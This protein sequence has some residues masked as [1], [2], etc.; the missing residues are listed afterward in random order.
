MNI[1][2]IS[3]LYYES[4]VDFQLESL[5]QSHARFSQSCSVFQLTQSTNQPLP[6]SAV[7]GPVLFDSLSVFS[8]TSP[9]SDIHYL[10]S[11]FTPPILTCPCSSLISRHLSVFLCCLTGQEDI[12]IRSC[13]I[14]SLLDNSTIF[15]FFFL[16]LGSHFLFDISVR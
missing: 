15:V 13:S 10:F 9:L 4:F 11:L 3:R 1:E 2:D 14:V 12:Y 8:E 6:K 7:T 16:G 5:L